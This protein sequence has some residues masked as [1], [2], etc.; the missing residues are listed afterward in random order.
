MSFK[1]VLKIVDSIGHLA[2]IHHFDCQTALLPVA[3]VR[4]LEMI[5]NIECLVRGDERHQVSRRGLGIAWT[6]RNYSERSIPFRISFERLINIPCG[7]FAVD[8]I[9]GI[10]LSDKVLFKNVDHCIL[11][12]NREN[13]PIRLDGTTDGREDDVPA[14]MIG[15]PVG[16]IIDAI[17]PIDPV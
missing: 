9:A 15:Y 2:P 12:V 6:R 16:D 4:Y 5:A 17:T 7:S 14:G 13:V 10:D 3:D 1:L 8:E 11:S